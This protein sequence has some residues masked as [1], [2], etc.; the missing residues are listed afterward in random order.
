[1]YIDSIV[2]E[3]HHVRRELLAAF[4][5]DMRA[6]NAALQRKEFTGFKMVHLEP[7]KP[8]AW[9]GG[10]RPLPLQGVARQ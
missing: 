2:E 5:G 3:V 9:N 8:F 10:V 1:M 6:Y 7:A 4:N